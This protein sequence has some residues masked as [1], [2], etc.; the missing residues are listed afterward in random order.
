M[1]SHF[2][3]DRKRYPEGFTFGLTAAC[4]AKDEP[5]WAKAIQMAKDVELALAYIVAQQGARELDEVIAFVGELKKN[6]HYQQ[7]VY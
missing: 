3:P 4:A 5:T 6:G 1:S 2:T 7:D